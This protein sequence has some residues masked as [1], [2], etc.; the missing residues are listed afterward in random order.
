MTVRLGKGHYKLA[1]AHRHGME[2]MEMRIEFRISRSKKDE[3]EHQLLVGPPGRNVRVRSNESGERLS[4]GPRLQFAA[5]KRELAATEFQLLAHHP[6]LVT[7]VSSLIET[8]V[9]S[10]LDPT[11]YYSG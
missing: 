10:V 4:S 9:S 8:Y 2:E 1:F 6:Q 11:A 5:T 7:I 3:D